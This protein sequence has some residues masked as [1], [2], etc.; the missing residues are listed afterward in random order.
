VRP[1][2]SIETGDGRLEHCRRWRQGPI[3]LRENQSATYHY[4]AAVAGVQT[5]GMHF[6]SLSAI[7]YTRGMALLWHGKAAR[8][9]EKTP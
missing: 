5:R 2:K 4:S 1:T 8:H 9:S 3:L 7:R 6:P